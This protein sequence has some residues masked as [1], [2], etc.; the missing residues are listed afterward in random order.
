MAQ[1]LQGAGESPPRQRIFLQ[2]SPARLG[3]DGMENGEMT[4]KS[5]VMPAILAVFPAVPANP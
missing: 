4:A 3:R 2:K 5:P 1:I